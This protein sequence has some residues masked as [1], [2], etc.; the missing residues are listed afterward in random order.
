MLFQMNCLDHPKFNSSSLKNVAWK[1]ILS[2]WVSVY[3]FSGNLLN[4]QGVTI[5]YT[6]H[7][8][9][10]V[11]NGCIS[12]RITFQ[13]K[14]VR[15]FPRKNPWIHGRSCGEAVWRLRSRSK[16]SVE[17][18]KIPCHRKA[19]PYIYIGIPPQKKNIIHN[20]QSLDLSS[21]WKLMLFDPW[22][23]FGWGWDS[24]SMKGRNVLRG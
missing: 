5:T 22:T 24:V 10:S 8:H 15:H 9:G 14:T 12:N 19:Y 16:S 17:G 6:S 13:K 21:V 7:N 1:T 2:F 11:K 3:I 18:P 4:F 23:T 20:Y